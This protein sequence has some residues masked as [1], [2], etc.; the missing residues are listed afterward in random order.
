MHA[1][2]Q[3][4][5][6]RRLLAEQLPAIAAAL[7]VTETFLKLGSFSAECVAFLGIWYV[8][9]ALVSGLRS[10]GSRAG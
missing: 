7:L 4:L 1:L 2:I 8:L 3:S 10:R 6:T 9:D 5:S